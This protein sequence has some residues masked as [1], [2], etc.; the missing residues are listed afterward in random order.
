MFQVRALFPT[1]ASMSHSCLANVRMLHRPGYKMIFRTIRKV[2][3]QIV[4]RFRIWGLIIGGSWGWAHPLLRRSIF[5]G[6]ESTPGRHSQEFIIPFLMFII[7]IIYHYNHHHHHHHNHHH[8]H[9]ATIS[10]FSIQIG[11]IDTRIIIALYLL[12]ML[13]LQELVLHMPLRALF[14]SNRSRLAHT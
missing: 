7:I 13:D 6:L 8:H 11:N 4:Y 1:M 9:F 3:T 12:V 2:Q 5:Q 10:V 14:K